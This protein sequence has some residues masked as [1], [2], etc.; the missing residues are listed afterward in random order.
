M[1]LNDCHQV[2]QPSNGIRLLQCPLCRALIRRCPRYGTAVNQIQADLELI[3]RRVQDLHRGL[4]EE[5]KKRVIEAMGPA[6][7]ERWTF[8]IA[9]Y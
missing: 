4:S 9:Q 5:E 7:G 8:T 2:E 6:A 1:S 3:K